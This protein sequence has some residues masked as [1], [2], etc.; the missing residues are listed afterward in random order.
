M[1]PVQ[2]KHYAVLTPLFPF[3]RLYRVRGGW[4]PDNPG[5]GEPGFDD[6]PV[7]VFRHVGDTGHLSLPNDRRGSLL[8]TAPVAVAVHVHRDERRSRYVPWMDEDVVPAER[9]VVRINPM[10]RTA[11]PVDRPPILAVFPQEQTDAWAK[12]LGDRWPVR[13]IAAAGVWRVIL[14]PSDVFAN[15]L[16]AP[17]VVVPVTETVRRVLE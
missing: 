8:V 15:T 16:A 9:L 10:T 7:F 11:P 4:V 3:P 1:M 5:K 14:L 2:R 17:A 6:K 12:A 13:E